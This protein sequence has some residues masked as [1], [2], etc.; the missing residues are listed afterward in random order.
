[1]NR[2]SRLSPFLSGMLTTALILGC[3][4][5]AQAAFQGKVSFGSVGVEI[6]RETAIE[7]GSQ[8]TTDAGQ[9]IPSSILYTDETGGGTTYLPLATISRMLELPVAWD[10]ESGNVL[11]GYHGKSDIDVSVDPEPGQ[12]SGA[13]NYPGAKAGRYTETEPRLPAEGERWS[14]FQDISFTSGMG[15]TDSFA[16]DDGSV[17]SVTVTNR[18]EFPLE[19]SVASVGMYSRASLPTSKVPAGETVTR[20]FSVG[21]YDGYF[22]GDDLSIRLGYDQD[23]LL[24]TSHRPSDIQADVVAVAYEGKK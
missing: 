21:E 7:K 4:T 5:V 12:S 2:H 8:L 17:I 18:S 10:G 1:M 24:S 15:F 11:L 20:T 22:Y 16:P 6:N 23:F 19:L 9:S 14:T 3:V 13:L